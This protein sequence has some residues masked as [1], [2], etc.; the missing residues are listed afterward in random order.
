LKPITIQNILDLKKTK[1]KF[2][3]ITAYDFNSAKLIDD[4]GI[5]LI[6]VGDSASMVV[7]GYSTTIPVTMEEMLMVL[8]AVVRGTKKT[9]VVADMPFLS[10]Q[11]S[12]SEAIKNAG[13]LIKEGGAGAVKLEGGEHMA[14]HIKNLVN[15][16]IPV[17]GHVGLTPQS[18]HQLSGYS[19]QGKTPET[20]KKIIDDARAV[21]EAGAFSV[22]LECV[23]S[24]LAEE[25]TNNLSIPTIGIGSGKSCDGQI[26]VFHD[27]LGLSNHSP[28]KHAMQYKNLN[29]EIAA[30]LQQY[31]S[32]IEK[33]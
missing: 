11:S 19:I 15:I 20:A 3:T 25:I 28:P 13:K 23:P 18:Y 22:V 2:A 9:L 29:Q 8:K 7:Y 21:Q 17:M 16:G 24:A 30:A 12:V 31:K 5:P 6:L 4:S 14:E 1:Q 32:D 10:Y 33:I 26:Q 27:V